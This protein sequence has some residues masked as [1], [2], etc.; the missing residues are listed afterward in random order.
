MWCTQEILGAIKK[1]RQWWRDGSFFAI[2]I[3]IEMQTNLGEK[4]AAHAC[5]NK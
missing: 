1:N 3:F 2:Y 5:K 4:L